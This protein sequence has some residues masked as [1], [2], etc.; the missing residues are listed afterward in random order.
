MQ[1]EGEN[2]TLEMYNWVLPA[3]YHKITVK[4]NGQSARTEKV[5]GDGN[6]TYTYQL[7]AFVDAVRNGAPFPT[8]A[9]DGVANM[10]VIDAIYD[11]AN[12]PRR[13]G[14]PLP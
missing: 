10:H 8:T 13:E 5:Y 11:K 3:I 9:A 6:T 14:K 7:R 4:L 12:M 1:V 2:G